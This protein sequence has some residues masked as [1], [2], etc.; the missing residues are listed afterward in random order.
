MLPRRGSRSAAVSPGFEE[1]C[2]GRRPAQG[3]WRL[4]LPGAS[5]PRLTELNPSGLQHGLSNSVTLPEQPEQ[6]C[7]LQ[8]LHGPI[9]AEPYRTK[10]RP[11]HPRRSWFAPAEARSGNIRTHLGGLGWRRRALPPGPNGLLRRSFIVIAGKA[12]TPN[13]GPKGAEKRGPRKGSRRRRRA[14]RSL[15]FHCAARG[16]NRLAF[17]RRCGYPHPARLSAG[18]P[19]RQAG[20]RK[21]RGDRSFRKRQFGPGEARAARPASDEA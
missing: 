2:A 10:T 7:R 9:S 14:E 13:I 3:K 12:G 15:K 6:S 4:L 18:H 21:G 16:K 17:H 20:V 1:F 5:G 19:R 8:L 11:L